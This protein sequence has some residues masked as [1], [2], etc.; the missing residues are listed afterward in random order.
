MRAGGIAACRVESVL[1]LGS[2][3]GM[4]E[5]MSLTA[6]C[7]LPARCRR[8]ASQRAK[9]GE[10]GAEAVEARSKKKLRRHFKQREAV[11]VAKKK[12][13]TRAPLPAAS[14]FGDV[15]ALRGS[16]S[17]LAASGAHA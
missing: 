3:A 4:L 9:A 16:L 10:G 6:R 5:E 14:V 8:V 15:R 2:C 13:L 1:A 17:C 7:A 11:G 12:K